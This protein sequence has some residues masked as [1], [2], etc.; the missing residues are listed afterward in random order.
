MF[1]GSDIDT[2]SDNDAALMLRLQAGDDACFAQIVERHQRRVFGLAYRFLGGRSDVEDAAQEVFIRVYRGRRTYKPTA[3]FT[4]WLYT[5][6]RN[7]CYNRL[8]KKAVP[9]VSFSGDEDGDAFL[10][11]T[12]VRTATPLQSMLQEERAKKV[13]KAI[14]ALPEGQ[15]MAVLLYRFEG[16]SYAEIGE[17]IGKSEKA[18]KSLLH[19]ARQNLKELLADYF[20]ES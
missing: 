1:R 6:C 11:P 20:E 10:Q 19:R 15:R 17:V 4:T 13:K 12:D 7:T 5:I 18:V 8:R 9:A 14:D 2:R 3:S 16:L